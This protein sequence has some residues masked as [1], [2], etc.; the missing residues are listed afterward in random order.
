MIESI[1]KTIT[2]TH[3]VSTVGGSII[4]GYETMVFVGGGTDEVDV[5]KADTKVQALLNHIAMVEK[6]M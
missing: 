1:A 4:G 6:Y 3:R 5:A 2:V